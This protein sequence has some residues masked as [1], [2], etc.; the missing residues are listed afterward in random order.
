MEECTPLTCSPLGWWDN[1]SNAHTTP[2][3]APLCRQLT[4]IRA[5]GPSL[6]LVIGRLSLRHYAQRAYTP[7]A[8]EWEACARS[9]LPCNSPL[10]YTLM[11]VAPK[12]EP[13]VSQ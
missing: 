9:S 5:C 3:G 4:H 11:S 2:T 12:S 13:S 7:E 1:Y 10:P 6:T 8:A